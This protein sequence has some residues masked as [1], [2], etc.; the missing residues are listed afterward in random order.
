MNRARTD[1]L[2]SPLTG[3]L[4]QRGGVRI[5][6]RRPIFPR[7]GLSEDAKFFTI[8]WAGGFVFFITFLG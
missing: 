4:V 7:A 5:A 2:Y 6:K 8:S 3:S 1:S